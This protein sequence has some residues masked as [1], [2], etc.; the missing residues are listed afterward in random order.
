MLRN[1]AV[2]VNIY[3]IKSPYSPREDQS[4]SEGGKKKRP[5]SIKDILTQKR[6][7]SAESSAAASSSSSETTSP[8]KLTNNKGEGKKRFPSIFNDLGSLSSS[9]NSG[10]PHNSLFNFMVKAGDVNSTLCPEEQPD[11]SVHGSGGGGGVRER[12]LW[13]SFEVVCDDVTKDDEADHKSWDDVMHSVASFEKE[14]EFALASLCIGGES[15][16]KRLSVPVV[17][18]E[19]VSL[20]GNAVVVLDGGGENEERPSSSSESEGK[21]KKANSS[22]VRC[23]WRNALQKVWRFFVFRHASQT[24]LCFLFCVFCFVCVCVLA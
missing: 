9:H 23:T 12:Y 7:G 3:R 1:L 18:L 20:L 5:S 16:A 14:D 8:S 21:E 4:L 2:S 11:V 17:S 24:F 15:Q 10:P 19:T 13:E 6:R 22:S